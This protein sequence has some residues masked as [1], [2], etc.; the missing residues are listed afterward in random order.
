MENGSNPPSEAEAVARRAANEEEAKLTPEQ[1]LRFRSKAVWDIGISLAVII[2]CYT[3]I[4]LLDRPLDPH[5]ATLISNRYIRLAGRP[6]YIIVV[7]GTAAVHDMNGYLY[8]GI[9]GLGLSIMLAWEAVGSLERPCSFFEP[10]GLTVLMKKEYKSESRN[11]ELNR[12]AN[13][14]RI[15]I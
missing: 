3:L 12:D 2:L 7:L 13:D 6:I 5:K 8:L 1:Y 10:K 11:A 15:P 4:A 14:M 9:C